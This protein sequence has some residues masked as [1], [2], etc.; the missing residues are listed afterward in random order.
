MAHDRNFESVDRE[1]IIGKLRDRKD[2]LRKVFGVTEIGLFGSY[3]RGENQHGSDVDLIV[4]FANVPSLLE[5]IRL[6]RYL[7]NLLRR[8]VET[9]RRPAIRSELRQQILSEAIY[10]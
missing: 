3:A 6:E 2:H 5:V 7:T 1:T 10:A 9:V 8:K 4:D